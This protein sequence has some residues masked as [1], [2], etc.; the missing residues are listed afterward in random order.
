MRYLAAGHFRPG[1][2]A[3]P[4][5][6]GKITNETAID[7][8]AEARL[9][10]PQLLT[11]VGG[12]AQLLGISVRSVWRLH[13]AHRI[14]EP[15]RLAG[16]VRWRVAEIQAWVDAGCPALDNGRKQRVK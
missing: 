11:A 2:E 7:A 6:M 5:I 13:S 8:A 15:I 14:P 4:S 9:P 10:H 12:V 3:R 16:N 1:L